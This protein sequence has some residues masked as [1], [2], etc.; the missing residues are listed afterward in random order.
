MFHADLKERSYFYL[1]MTHLGLKTASQSVLTSLMLTSSQN[2][3]VKNDFSCLAP[4]LQKHRGRLGTAWPSDWILSFC[5]LWVRP[6]AAWITETHSLQPGLYLVSSLSR[7]Y[8]FCMMEVSSMDSMEP[9]L[10]SAISI[11]QGNKTIQDGILMP[12]ALFYTWLVPLSYH[13]SLF[14]SFRFLNGESK[15]SATPKSSWKVKN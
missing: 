7:Q 12:W 15:A 2:E 6:S 5:D 14:P 1:D 4:R 9:I 11:F 3:S 8:P 13:P 10:R